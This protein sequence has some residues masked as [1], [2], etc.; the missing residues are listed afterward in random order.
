MHTLFLREHNR[1][2]GKLLELNINWDGETIYQETRKIISGMIQHI[3]FN[4]WLPTVLGK[5]VYYFY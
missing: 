4:E 2:A 3:T 5:V 1:I